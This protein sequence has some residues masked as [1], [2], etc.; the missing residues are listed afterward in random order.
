MNHDRRRRMTNID[1]V[2]LARSAWVP[3]LALVPAPG[4]PAS[5]QDAPPGAWSW[6]A[7]ANFIVGYNN[8][9]RL[10]ADFSAWESQNW[11]MGRGERPLGGGRF[12]IASMLS[13]EPFTIPAEGSPQL[14]QTGET[15]RDVPLVNRQ[16]PHDL[17]MELGATSRLYACRYRR[18]RQRTSSET[19]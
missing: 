12:T 10:F 18:S 1:P 2:R 5:A 7:D 9:R 15:Y 8:Q 3:L 13:L 11:F 14:F 16:H 6:S 19:W 4:P 17:V